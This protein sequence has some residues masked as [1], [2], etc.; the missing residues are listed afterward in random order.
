MLDVRKNRQSQSPRNRRKGCE[1]IKNSQ[2]FGDIH[3]LKA[4]ET[5]GREEAAHDGMC[6]HFV[7]SE[8]SSGQF[9]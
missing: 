2:A 1:R 7:I 4:S 3:C 6:D 8:I 5:A 9:D